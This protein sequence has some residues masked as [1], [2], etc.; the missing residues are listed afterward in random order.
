MRKKRAGKKGKGFKGREF[1][2]ARFLWV[3]GLCPRLWLLNFLFKFLFSYAVPSAGKSL[4]C[5]LN[6][7]R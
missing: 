1:L 3:R 5:G 6:S 2:P 4:L 7:A